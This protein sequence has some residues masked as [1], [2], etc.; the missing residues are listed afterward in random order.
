M[1]RLF[2]VKDVTVLMLAE[3][4]SKVVSKLPR[5][6]PIG[7]DEPTLEIS[8]FSCS[9]LASVELLTASASVLTASKDD[10][11]VVVPVVT[12]PTYVC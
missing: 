9:I 8:V 1:F 2:F 12:D 6:S 11:A 10:C 3:R 7:V 4:L 5:A